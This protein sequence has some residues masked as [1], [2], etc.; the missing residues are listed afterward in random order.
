[1]SYTLT[2]LWH[3][4]QRYL[5][6]V[7][8]ISFSALLMALQTGLLLGLFSITSLPVDY[9]ADNLVWIG[10]PEVVSVDLGQSIRES[11][12]NRLAAQ[13]EVIRCEPYFQ[14]FAYWAQRTGKR[15]LC[16]VVGSRLGEDTLGPAGKLLTAEDRRKLL[17]PGAIIIPEGDMERLGVAYKRDEQGRIVEPRELVNATAEVNG[18]AV[19]VVAVKPGIKSL[20]GP[21]I[22]CSLTTARALLRLFP[23]QVTYVVGQCAS[24][25]DTEKVVKR[26]RAQYGVKD[27]QHSQVNIDCAPNGDV[28][29]FSGAEFSW[30]TRMH[31]LTKTKGGYALGYAALLGL[32]IGAVVTSQTL[33][34]ATAASLKEFAVLRALGIPRWRMQ[35]LVLGQAFWMGAV[36]LLLALPVAWGL[37]SVAEMSQVPINLEWWILLLSGSLTLFMAMA[38]GLLALRS[39]RNVEPATLLR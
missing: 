10:A 28:A 9:A 37:K 14:G 17:Q 24:A 26:L 33:Y 12:I 5:P 7:L 8:A 38:A 25:A 3:D 27:K 15:E 29:V 4:R 1:M 31:W 16:M 13:P 39:L 32:I 21:Y 34:A 30:Q 23:D 36:G 6:G 2:T 11:T 35:F 20:A 18:I 22:F 19:R